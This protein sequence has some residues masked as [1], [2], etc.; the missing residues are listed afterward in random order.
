MSR[1]LA[2]IPLTLALLAS[3]A[4]SSQE[5]SETP[6]AEEAVVKGLK[7]RVF[8]VKNRSPRDLRGTVALLGSGAFGARMECNDELQTITVRDYPENLATIA[9]ALTRL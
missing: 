5:K 8:E 3:P 2:L 4:R 7:S 9:D 6:R 1:T